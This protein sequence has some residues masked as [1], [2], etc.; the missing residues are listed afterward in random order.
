MPAH[1]NHRYR[2]VAPAAMAFV[3]LLATL[4]YLP[5]L[6]SG[7]YLDDF[8]NLQLLARVKEQGL[9]AFVGSGA[10]GPFG[11]PLAYLSFALQA[12]SWPGNLAAF[13]VVNLLLHLGN[14]VLVYFLCRAIAPRVDLPQSSQD[15]FCIFSTG[16]WL[17][18]PM[19][20][21]TVLYI[22]Q[23]MTELAA[24]FVLLGVLAYLAGRRMVW[25]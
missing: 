6:G 14:G 22:V 24:A 7:M 13:K 3:L 2:F 1:V 18:H 19:H 4:V 8:Y 9:L 21:S 17:I 5:G 20:L 11:R 12:G 16:L 15:L 25:E 10:S 23:R